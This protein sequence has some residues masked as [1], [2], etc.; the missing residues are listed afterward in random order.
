MVF[1]S[2]NGSEQGDMDF[3]ISYKE[4]TGNW[5]EATPINVLNTSGNELTPFLATN[6]TLYFASNGW[7]GLGGYDIFYS[8][9][10]NGTWQKPYPLT[11][12]NTEFDESDLTILP[13]D[14][15]VFSSNRP[16][17]LGELDLYLTKRNISDKEILKKQEYEI[18]IAAQS[19]TISYS[20]E[21]SKAL[22]PIIP[23]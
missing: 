16:G 8:V 1:V 13:N 12:I 14:Y 6:D 10:E 9:F 21:K 18:S 15:A 17:G 5:A 3:W 4:S 22:Y 7:G 19:T 2:N 11:E 23:F 20:I